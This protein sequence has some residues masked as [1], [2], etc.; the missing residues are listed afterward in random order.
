MKSKLKHL[1]TTH[2]FNAFR[3]QDWID[4]NGE[5]GDILANIVVTI[6]N[7]MR[8]NRIRLTPKRYELF[9]T[10]I[11]E[12]TKNELKITVIIP[13]R[14]SEER[15]E[16]LIKTMQKNEMIIC[17]KTET[18]TTAIAET[19][20]DKWVLRAEVRRLLKELGYGR[21]NKKQ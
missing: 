1:R 11:S 20:E 9:K 19:K 8:R 12:V 3:K 21:F 5:E 2:L 13:V 7:E 16:K 14:K 4:P 10:I 18:I 15:Y 17:L 6:L